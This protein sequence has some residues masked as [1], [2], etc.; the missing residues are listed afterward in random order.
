M[1]SWKFVNLE[2]VIEKWLMA[3]CFFF[4]TP[5]TSVMHGTGA[6]LIDLAQNSG[7]MPRVLILG[8]E[9]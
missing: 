8:V 4:M 9:P 6:A 7:R 3:A 1:Q 5:S 2:I